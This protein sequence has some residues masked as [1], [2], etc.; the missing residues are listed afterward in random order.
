MLGAVKRLETMHLRSFKKHF[1]NIIAGDRRGKGII[2]NL[3]PPPTRRCRH[4]PGR[5]ICRW[6]RL[7]AVGN[8]SAGCRPLDAAL[9]ICHNL[10]RRVLSLEARAAARPT[11]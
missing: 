4:I 6:R 9:N 2:E 5:Q 1:F 10:W 3:E 11:Y 8:D 7:N